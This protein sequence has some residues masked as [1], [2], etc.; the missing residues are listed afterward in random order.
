MSVL[1]L[2]LTGWKSKHFRKSRWHGYIWGIVGL[3]VDALISKLEH[4]VRI[5]DS[6]RTYSRHLTAASWK[7]WC[8]LV[9]TVDTLFKAVS[10]NIAFS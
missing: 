7:L 9:R 6:T 4:V 1:S 3:V 2:L 10:M 5:L 8:K